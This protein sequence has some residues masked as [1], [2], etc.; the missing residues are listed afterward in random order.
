M[1][2]DDL[3]LDAFLKALLSLP[4]APGVS[5]RG[6]V[7]PADLGT[8][9]VATKLLTAASV[10][11]AVATA[12]FTTSELGIV[13]GRTGRDL[14]AFSAMPE[15]EE[16]TYAPGRIFRTPILGSIWLLAKHPF[17]RARSIQNNEVK[18]A[19]INLSQSI[20]RFV[21]DKDI[22]RSKSLN[23]FYQNFTSFGI[24][25]VRNQHTCISQIRE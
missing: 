14:G 15:A 20:R 4:P 23:V 11:I 24:D 18:I 12:G 8:V 2:S 13:V 19:L 25:F 9:D 17:A 3:N 6:W 22:S 7:H 1:T 10:D 16:I 5:F 21:G